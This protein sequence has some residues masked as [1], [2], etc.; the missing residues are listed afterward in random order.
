MKSPLH[1]LAFTLIELL[2]VI[3]ILAV[4]VGLLLPAVQKSRDAAS[5]SRSIG[6][7]KQIA[8]AAHSFASRSSDAQFPS[9]D[10]SY[11]GTITTINGPYA[12]IL[13]EIEQSAVFE[14]GDRSAVIKTLISPADTTQANQTA[15]TSYAWNGGW[16]RFTKG[17]AR[18]AVS[19]GTSNTI[20]L[21]E[22]PMTCQSQN[23]TWSA[24]HPGQ[25]IT[26]NPS[27]GTSAG[28]SFYRY[29]YIPGVTQ[30]ANPAGSANLARNQEATS[31]RPPAGT[32]LTYATPADCDIES[33]AG[34]HNGIILVAMGD[35]SARS[36]SFQVASTNWTTAMTTSQD[37]ILDTNW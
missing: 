4:M 7:L 11:S 1:R 19:D 36:V 16:I 34:L 21:C 17:N 24:T 30:G 14:N 3:A 23:N 10:F 37:D 25:T 26:A 35:G 8:L 32:N 2:V 12:A 13:P 29:P 5:R 15:L 33:P 31:A 18:V 20:L 22:K 27:Y 9:G 28:N 6:N